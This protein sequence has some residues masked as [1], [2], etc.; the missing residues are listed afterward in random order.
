MTKQ[1][2]AY[3]TP[4]Y[5]DEKSCLGGGERYPLN[6]AAGVVHASGGTCA[7]E[8]VSYGDV[9]DR[10]T[11]RPGVTLRILR[12]DN[13]P[14]NRLDVV[15][16]ELCG[17]IADADLVHIHM[18]Y[19]RSNELAL[20]LAKMQRKPVYLTDHGGMSSTIGLNLGAAE[21]ADRII[22]YSDF[23]ASLYETRQPIEV[24]KGG[25]DAA[26]FTPAPS[27]VTRD[28]VLYVGRLLPHKGID[29]LI[30]ALPAA[31][32]LTI[33]GRPYHPQY[34]E[35]LQQLAVGK[36]VEFVTDADEAKLLDLYRRAWATVLPS[37][38]Q[39]C[40]GN[41]YTAPELMGFTLLESMACGTPAIASRVGAMPEFIREGETGFVFDDL[42]QLSDQLGLLAGD[43]DLV[44]Q[45]GHRGRQ[46]VE[47][48]YDL[49]VA[50]RKM[51]DVYR[52]G[53]HQPQQQEAAA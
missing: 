19:T 11:L 8:L 21:L 27:P 25:V 29:Q 6:L 37:V 51:L 5:F 46:V 32:R 3:L 44:E 7:V 48:E 41:S 35:L 53:S 4:L 33:C 45:M 12:A 24:I 28:R 22:A 49:K 34:F 39:D 23:G 40:Y 30:K 10:R 2:I 16:W 9:S 20:V 1:K 14:A 18:A 42:A 17:A 36:R 13:R 47:Q 15:S 43:V 50:G 26:H 31:L 52:S 38:Y